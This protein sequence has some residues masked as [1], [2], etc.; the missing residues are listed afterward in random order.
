MEVDRQPTE[1]LAANTSPDIEQWWQY[2]A[3]GAAKKILEDR[4]DMETVAKI[5]PEFKM[6]ERLALRRTLVQNKSQRT[7]TI[8]TEQASL[9]ADFD[10]FNGLV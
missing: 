3:Y 8:Y 6:Q 7:P 1:L 9:G 2:I 10:N 4:M 5:A